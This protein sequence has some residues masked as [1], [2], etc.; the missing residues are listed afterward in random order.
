MFRQGPQTAGVG[1]QGCLPRSCFAPPRRC[2]GDE[3]PRGNKMSGLAA[4]AAQDTG[5]T[6]A[7]TRPASTLG[8]FSWA[9]YQWARDPYF[10]IVNIYVFAPYFSNVVVGDPVKGQALWGYTT[11]VAAVFMALFSPVLGAI[12]DAGGRRKPWILACTLISLPCMW[13]LWF[14]TPGMGAEA[15]TGLWVILLALILAALMSEFSAVFHNAML[16]GIAS[17]RRLGAL[18]GLGLALT[19]LGGIITLLIVLLAFTQAEIPLFGLDRA[20]HEHDRVVGPLSALWLFAFCLPFFLFTPDGVPSHRTAVQAVRV[21]LATLA[22]TL[23]QL[24]HYRN[25]GAYLGARMIF[26][27]G[28]IVMLYFGGIYAAG[29]FKWGAA[30][31]TVYGILNSIVA[32]LG[33]LVGGWLDDRLGSRRTLQISLLGCI[34]VGLGT[35][36]IT[37]T[38][39]F[40]MAVPADAPALAVPVFHSL[41]EQVY[42]GLVFLIAIFITSGIA[43]SRTMLARIAPP[44]MMTEFFGLFALSGNATSFMGP[45]LLAV[46]T[47]AFHS[48]RIGFLTC[49]VF[50]IVGLVIL[51]LFVREERTAAAAH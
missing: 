5:L 8:Q 46:V 28:W 12:A 51:T 19:N 3:E 45:L 18:S 4:E 9:L 13:M 47:E 22:G 29:V 44:E 37:P 34:V 6:V 24:K 36:S 14:A 21:G 50:L 30:E 42:V 16:P 25:V 48:Q 20:L 23:R 35:I 26:G 31:L 1:W 17:E 41:H 2:N 10:L 49:Q 15:G 27:D 7:G 33:A 43:S 39:I 32:A 11:S 40:F 38:E